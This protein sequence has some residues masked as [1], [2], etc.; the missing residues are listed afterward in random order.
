MG[1]GFGLSGFAEEDFALGAVR[2]F[3]G[4]V[5]QAFSFSGKAIFEGLGLLEPATL[6][7]DW[8]HAYGS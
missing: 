8:P 1:A 6:F 4:L 5:F 3:P 2:E 7:H